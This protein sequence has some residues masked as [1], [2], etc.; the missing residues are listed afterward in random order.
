[1][2][3]HNYCNKSLIKLLKTKHLVWNKGVY[4][5]RS[6]FLTNPYLPP[7]S[8]CMQKTVEGVNP[9]KLLAETYA[10]PLN[11]GAIDKK[12]HNSSGKVYF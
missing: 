9:P 8:Q 4:D 6:R 2:P 3:I 5:Y 7:I 11:K 12:V 10:V 1:M